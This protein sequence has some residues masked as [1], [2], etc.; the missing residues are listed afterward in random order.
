MKHKRL[1]Q[2][3]PPPLKRIAETLKSQDSNAD[4]PLCVALTGASGFLGSCILHYFLES[5]VHV[6]ALER[7][8]KLPFHQNLTIIPGD[9]RDSAALARLVEGAESVI[10][11]GGAVAARNAAGFFE[12]NRE[13]TRNIVQAAQG[14]GVARFLYIS[15]MAAREPGLSPYA[16]SKLEGE[17]V[18]E[19]SAL[20]WDII[21]PPAIYGPGDRQILPLMRLLQGRVGLLPGG[22]NARVSVIYVNDLA[23]AAFCWFSS[24]RAGCNIYEIDDGQKNGYSWQSLL[25]KA[26]E[27]MN[28]R[29]CYVAPPRFLMMMVGYASK[30]L[31]ALFGKTSFL[32]PDKLRELSHPDWVRKDSG[33]I[34]KDIGWSAKTDFENGIA[35]TLRWWRQ[36]GLL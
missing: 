1:K 18:L 29:A 10:H 16:Q 5:G 27:T 15:S 30:F 23:E 26:A 35:K 31:A 11:C 25:D 17:Q 6:R 24:G 12:A 34:E 33:R 2:R 21:R 20:Q 32:T 3:K 8:T 13:G 28:I 9:L 36:E 7:R 4:K 22:R 14:A 19:G